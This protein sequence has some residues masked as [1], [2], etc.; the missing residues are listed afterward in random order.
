[1]FG[2]AAQAQTIVP[3]TTAD[4]QMFLDAFNGIRSETAAGLRPGNG[5]NLPAAGNMNSLFW[6]EGLAQVAANGAALCTLGANPERSAQLQAEAAAGNTRFQITVGPTFWVGETAGFSMGVPGM[7]TA[8]PLFDLWADESLSWT[9]GDSSSATCEP[10]GNGC[11]HWKQL[12]WADTRWVGCGIANCDG[13]SSYRTHLVCNFFTGGNFGPAAPYET[14]TPCSACQVDRTVCEDVSL[15]GG[16][17]D[18]N[19][20]CG[21]CDPGTPPDFCP[22]VM[23]ACADDCSTFD[24]CLDDATLLAVRCNT[25]TQLCEGTNTSC[26]SGSCASNMCTEPVPAVGPFALWL[27]MGAVMTAGWMAARRRATPSCLGNSGSH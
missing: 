15:C 5:G 6:D 24:T 26:S 12:V 16:C 19:F 22:E 14:G 23:P 20:D 25:T 18:P 3:L 1:M 4:K 13:V 7:G 9:Y 8:L 21:S 11:F 10:S 27:L 17:P 2:T